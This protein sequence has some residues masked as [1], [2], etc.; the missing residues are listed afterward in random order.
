MENECFGLP[1]GGTIVG[2]TIGA[3]IL[4]AGLIWLLQQSG[5]VASNVSVWPFAIMIFGIL[6]IL[7][8]LYGRR[9]RFY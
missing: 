1:R 7:G 9:S 5:L 6:I 4:L 3:I 8:A 2:L